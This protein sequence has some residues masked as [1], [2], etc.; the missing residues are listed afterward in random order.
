MGLV[1]GKMRGE[2]RQV[3]A[4][5]GR[6]EKKVQNLILSHP[7]ILLPHILS[8]YTAI[9]CAPSLTVDYH[10]SNLLSVPPTN[11]FAATL[12]SAAQQERPLLRQRKAAQQAGRRSVRV[13]CRVNGHAR[14]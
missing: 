11:S 9:H 13:V 1:C 2:E 14:Q 6:R 3:Q 10:L 5:N 12:C 4:S 8:H 7:L